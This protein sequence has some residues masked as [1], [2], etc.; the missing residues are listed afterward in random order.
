MEYLKSKLLNSALVLSMP[1][2]LLALPAGETYAKAYR[3]RMVSRLSVA[4][5][6][7]EYKENP[8]GIDET[9]PR[10]SW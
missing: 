7:T 9:R 5:L 10:L 3:L 2:L 4:D 6:R 8:L 1:L